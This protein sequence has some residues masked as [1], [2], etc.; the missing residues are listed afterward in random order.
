EYFR[1]LVEVDSDQRLLVQEAA[2][3]HSFIDERVLWIRSAEP[4]MPSDAKKAASAIV[5]LASPENW[6]AAAQSAQYQIADEPV[7]TAAV[8]IAF[9]VALLARRR[10]KRGIQAWARPVDPNHGAQTSIR[11]A[12]KT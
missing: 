8:F 9:S 10:L 2:Q 11:R 7:L 6:L 1:K 4:M 12:L 3:Y 5:G